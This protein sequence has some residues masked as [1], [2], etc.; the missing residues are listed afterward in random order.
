MDETTAMLEKEEAEQDA[1]MQG[2]YSKVSSPLLSVRLCQ[3]F[4]PWKRNHGKLV[5][6]NKHWGKMADPA[7]FEPTG[8]FFPTD[9]HETDARVGD[10]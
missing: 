8:L 1:R 9:S 10:L 3:K 5:L 2:P 6:R 4:H 7:L